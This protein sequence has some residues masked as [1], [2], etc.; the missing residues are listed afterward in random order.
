MVSLFK[1]VSAITSIALFF[2]A[3]KI[4]RYDEMG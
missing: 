2:L 1:N 4:W 3:K